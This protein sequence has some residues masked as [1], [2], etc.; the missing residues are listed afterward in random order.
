MAERGATTPME[1]L[2]QESRP[3]EWD[4]L[5]KIGSEDDLRDYMQDRFN[6]NLA[7]RQ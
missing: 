7:T 5:T 4:E 3:I 6:V 2:R 1:T